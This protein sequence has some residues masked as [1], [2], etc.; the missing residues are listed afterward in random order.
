MTTLFGDLK[1][2]DSKLKAESTTEQ[3]EATSVDEELDIFV[4]TTSL[5]DIFDSDFDLD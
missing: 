3:G 1:E 2:V 4:D 5:E